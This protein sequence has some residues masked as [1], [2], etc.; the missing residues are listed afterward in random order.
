[1]SFCRS[2]KLRKQ[3]LCGS[4]VGT[5]HVPADPPK[6]RSGHSRDNQIDPDQTK[7]TGLLKD[8]QGP[9][10][11]LRQIDGPLEDSR[12]F[13]YR[14]LPMLTIHKAFLR[15]EMSGLGSEALFVSTWGI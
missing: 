7:T 2:F 13:C 3:S 12:T 14:T 6:C 1:M 4:K 8:V 10:R 15:I 9:F 5:F 11:C